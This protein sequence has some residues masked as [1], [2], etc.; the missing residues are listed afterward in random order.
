MPGPEITSSNYGVITPLMLNKLADIPS[1]T[2]GVAVNPFTVNASAVPPK[3]RAA[4]PFAV[5]GLS[6][7][8]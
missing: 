6:A 5:G 8:S 3:V 7:S 4:P 1:I 2:I